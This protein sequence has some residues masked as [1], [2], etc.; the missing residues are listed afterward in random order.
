[1]KAFGDERIAAGEQ[2]LVVDLGACT[3]MDSTFMG[4]L[5][6][7]ATRISAQPGGALQ[8]AAVGQRNRNSLEDLGLDFFMEIEPPEAPWHHQLEATRRALKPVGP[9]LAGGKIQQ[10]QHVLEAHQIL[11]GANDENA[12]KFATVV[13]LL[14]VELEKKLEGQQP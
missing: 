13:K 9:K 6:G 14:G 8:I 5:G 11:A 10:A 1:M 7:L 3:G 2:R 4:T 12:Q